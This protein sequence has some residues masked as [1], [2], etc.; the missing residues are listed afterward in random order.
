MPRY[1]ET[2]RVQVGAVEHEWPVVG[3][4]D[5]GDCGVPIF[6]AETGNT[7]ADGEPSRMPVDAEPDAEGLHQPHWTTC[8]NPKR[9][10]RKDDRRPSAG[11]RP[12]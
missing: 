4:K 9:F 12:R 7:R 3:M 1:P 6:F 2:V 5:C 11:D 10:R 8:S